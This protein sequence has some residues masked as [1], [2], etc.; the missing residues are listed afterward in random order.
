MRRSLKDQENS[1]PDAK[2][3]CNSHEATPT[4]FPLP[5]A[6]P[7]IHEVLRLETIHS[8]PSLLSEV[9]CVR[10]V[11]K[12]CFKNL[13]VYFVIS[14]I[15]VPVLQTVRRPSLAK[16]IRAQYKVKEIVSEDLR[17]SR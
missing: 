7:S 8:V 6:P 10:F 12:N 15:P 13:A 3:L 5:V 11:K 9:A 14:G 1:S 2:I 17:F 16:R 4:P